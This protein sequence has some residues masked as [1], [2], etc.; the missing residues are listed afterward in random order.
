MRPSPSSAL[1][2][3]VASL[4]C[5]RTV[6]N[7]GVD[8]IYFVAATPP[9]NDSPLSYPASLY[10]IGV[11]KKLLLV[12]QFFT[13]EQY[14]R[15]LADDLDGKLYVAG[16]SGVFIVHQNDP[17]REDFV[18][19][20]S[21][22]DFPCWGVTR[23]AGIPSAMQYCFADQLIKVLGDAVQ[24]KPR[25]SQGDWSA[26]QFLQFGGENGGPFQAQPPLA[27]MKGLDLVM[28][29]SFRPNVVVTRLPGEFVP[30][31]TKRRTVTIVAATDRY[32]ALWIPPD[33]MVNVGSIDANNPEHTEPTE[34]LLLDRLVSRWGKF[35]LPTTTTSV[36]HPAVRIFGDWTVTTA[37]EWRI[38][39]RSTP[40]TVEHGRATLSNLPDVH[41][42]F[43]N[44]FSHVS[45]PGKL[46]FQN[47]VDG[48]KVMLDVGNEDS[49]VLAIRSN[50]QILYRVNDSIYS[51]EISGDHVIG[52][53]LIVKDLD[54]L[55]IHWAFW[56]PSIMRKLPS[57]GSGSS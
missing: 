30:S 7:S 52:S 21:F 27:E 15:D 3:L 49:E 25:V 56:G 39:A 42:E 54:A 32:L 45:I 37:M 20:E 53:T 44:R 57:K 34:I 6:A 11:K 10:G 28:P 4:L 36:T 8:T 35:E 22:D 23:G 33:S 14:F 13:P 51:A 17:T 31:P 12:R 47:L 1:I 9:Q 46:I 48:R 41:A 26:F 38:K 50:G 16:Q 18:S 55:Q 29:Y 2:L 5:S 43:L 40:T 24:G 19:Y